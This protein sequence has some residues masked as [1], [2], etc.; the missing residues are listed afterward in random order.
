MQ[1]SVCKQTQTG[2]HQIH[3]RCLSY[4]NSYNSQIFCMLKIRL[5]PRS[6][7][8]DTHFPYTTLFRSN[9]LM[10]ALLAKGPAVNCLTIPSRQRWMGAHCLTA[11]LTSGCWRLPCARRMAIWWT[12]RLS[13]TSVTP[14]VTGLTIFILARRSP[15]IIP[16]ILIVRF[17]SLEIGRAHV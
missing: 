14:R 9:D 3:Q 11:R 4:I 7:H 1:F 13:G 5:P 8:T 6:T 2:D 15:S 17:T 10:V 12:R 16:T